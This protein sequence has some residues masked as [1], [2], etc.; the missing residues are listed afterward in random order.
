M[1]RRGAGRP[2][3][4]AGRRATDWRQTHGPAHGL[5]ARREVSPHLC[6][7]AIQIP[8]L[9]SDS[10]TGIR[11]NN[12][13]VTADSHTIVASGVNE[14]L[15][16]EHLLPRRRENA[17][18]RLAISTVRLA[19]ASVVFSLGAC[20]GGGGGGDKTPTA[21]VMVLTT[22]A[23]SVGSATI[24][25]G[26]S[27]QANA[28]GLDQNGGAIGTGTVTWS[29]SSPAVATIST[30][31]AIVAVSPGQ[32][33]ITGAAGSRSGQTTLTVIPVPV[34]SVTV[35][36]AAPSIIIGSTQQLTAATL[37]ASN[38]PLSGR[39]VTWNTSDATKATVT[40]AG[41]VTGVAVGTATITA[42]SEGKAGSATVTILPIPVATVI[43]SPAASSVL[44][45]STQQ[46]TVST[47]DA[48]NNALTGRVVV[49]SSSDTT[50]AKVSV[51]GLVT[52]VAVGSATVTA[53]SEGKSGAASVTILPIPVATITVAPST[54]NISVGATQ[55]FTATTKDVGGNTL[56]GRTITWSSSNAAVASVSVAGAVTGIA[57]GTA[58]VTAASEG[59][60]GSAAVTVVFVPVAAVTI[61]P[62]SATISLNGTV[63]LTATA[64]DANGAVL[65]G[66]TFSW[67]SS[68]LS[69]VS[70]I[71]V[72][73]VLTAQGLGAGTAVLT[74]TSEGKSGTSTV[75]VVALPPAITSISPSTLV[76]GSS[77]TIT[78]S[79]FGSSTSANIVKLG[80]ATAT[81]TSASATQLIATVPCV[82][83]GTASVTVTANTLV[84]QG[85]NATVAVTTRTLA[86]GQSL[87]LLDE[88][89]VRCNELPVTGGKY[90]VGVF[91]TSTVPSSNATVS[92]FGAAAGAASVA[93]STTQS[94]Q[95]AR[96]VRKA[97]SGVDASQLAEQQATARAHGAMLERDRAL[98]AQMRN[99][100][101][102]A[103]A[104]ATERAQF[105]TQAV[106]VPLTAGSVITMRNRGL[107]GSCN[108]A[109][110]A[111]AR[112][113]AVNAR[114]IVL[115]DNASPTAGQVD[116][117]L[118][119]LGQTFES[120]Q[121]AVLSN[122]GDIN[123][124]D[125]PGGFDNPGRVV[126]FFTPTENVS[127]SG[128]GIVLGHI[129]GC[130]WYPATVYAGS[131]NTKIFYARVPTLLSG[132]INTQDTKAWWNSMMPGTLVHEAKHLVS[133]AEHFSR[134]T[135]SLEESWLEEGTA[136]M[137]AELYSRSVYAG[138]GWKTNTAY[139]NSV[140]CDV[141][142]GFPACPNGQSLML[143]HF[144]W[145]FSY[146]QSNDGLSFLSP[147]S[148]D[149][150]IYGS[151]WMFA[152]WL[153]DQYGGA[154]EATLL[155]ALTQE[156]SATGVTNVIK[157]TGQ[158]FA[159][160][161][162]DWVMMLVADDYPG[163][164]PATGAKY[165]FPSW[166]TRS[167]WSGLNTAYQNHPV[168]PLNAY[169]AANFG[170]FSITGS[171][172][173][174]SAAFMEV[175]GTQST[176]QL[177]NLNGLPSGT[178]IRMSILRIQ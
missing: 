174:A 62:V 47:V 49:W 151:A 36:P 68:N 138:S 20:S 78:G 105:R 2:T 120:T 38:G 37:D 95:I 24:Q 117:E 160:L 164:T 154:T 123:A 168:F 178:T 96:T 108:S 102:V 65:A 97:I 112:V 165:T 147:G 34:A 74:A 153:V 21:P 118:I 54:A 55:A 124:Y 46:L 170:S 134:N 145:L 72:G 106:V 84:S 14:K 140:Y 90:L 161:L 110:T 130:D 45:G 12:A 132:S 32:T 10:R 163:F 16:G 58:T 171:L 139:A 99:S 155:R 158:Q 114:S 133:Y 88:A 177:L 66:R 26:Q 57:A 76:P 85:V 43:V 39:T 116:A 70:G 162:A 56:T 25:V 27:T 101:I 129:S 30:S 31:G 100:P 150:T 127:A 137:S 48:S 141:Y 67:T 82:S 152:R 109:T 53:T 173:G 52:A 60:T 8:I 126:M 79:G 3:R 71:F 136:Q 149:G 93:A 29:S 146:Y 75:T 125:L 87:S 17:M 28:A 42:T 15:A 23:V 6:T 51:T 92:L 13:K 176:K 59:K 33:T 128:G 175:S 115:E 121:Y 107:S 142:R 167:I 44:V 159:T 111:Q 80:S 156:S 135:A 169:Y 113:V 91:N 104:R 157:Q 18:R 73:N 63:V 41:L 77:M 5:L 131:N 4:D 122:F 50:R 11:E 40:S 61:A 98:Y 9:N 64:V 83:S 69:V 143:N 86:V 144:N 19:L 94:F 35:A 103:A 119:A 166:N 22:V 81:V 148:T 7:R 89:S 1:T 172:P